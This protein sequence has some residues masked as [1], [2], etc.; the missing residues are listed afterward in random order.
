MI[1]PPSNSDR[2]KAQSAAFA[3]LHPALQRW[4]WT[5]GWPSLRDIQE[6]AI[7]AILDGDKDILISAAT[8]GGKTEA[9]ILP[10]LTRV[11]AADTP[12]IRVMG[13]SPLKALINDQYRRLEEIGEAVGLPIHRWHGDV[14]EANKSRLLKHPA[15]L[16][17]ITPESLEAMFVRRGTLIRNLFAGLGFIVVDELHAFVGSERGRQLQTLLHRLEL[18]LRRRVPRIGLSAT[19]GDMGMAAEFLRPAGGT[20]VCQIASS[21]Q[22]GEVRLQLR[23]YI[24]PKMRRDVTEEQMG[25]SAFREIVEHIYENLRRRHNL[26]FVNQKSA[27]EKYSD[28]LRTLCETRNVPNEFFPHHGSLSKGLRE[29][30]E[31]MLKSGDTPVSAVCTSTLELGIDIGDVE[32][33]AQI[34][35]PPAVASMRQRLGRSGRRGEPAVL[36]I[37]IDEPEISPATPVLDTMRL[38]TFETAAMVSLLVAGWCEPPIPHALHLSTLL[39]QSL[40]AIAQVGGAKAQ[41]LWQGLCQSGPFLG[42]DNAMFAAFLRSLAA[43]GLLVQSSEGVLLLGE[44]GERLVNNYDFYSA[45]VTDD[46]YRIEHEGRPLGSIPINHALIPGQMLIFGGR[47]WT[48]QHVDD[49]QKRISVIPA[50]G[51]TPPRYFGGGAKIHDRV[52]ENMFQLYVGHDVP[53]FLDSGAKKL[54]AQGRESFHEL[55]LMERRIVQHGDDCHTFLWTG[56]RV[57]DTIVALL[58]QRNVSSAPC[59]IC[60]LTSGVDER[61]II[62][63]FEA[64]LSEPPQDPKVLASAVRNKRREKHDRFLTEELLCADYASRDLDVEGARRVL[65][66]VL[67]GLSPIAG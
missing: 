60:L 55:R 58:R 6:R 30:V 5:Q 15:G 32:T 53:A 40:S 31:R 54:F 24:D 57:L 25:P 17:L 29:D 59:A 19:I 42:I 62:G 8:A 43:N 27:V 47:R 49:E 52:R 51:G 28:G 7:P 38:E 10:I 64:I 34:G 16:L 9:A 35:S 21:D 22:G 50:R 20:H 12:G 36:R 2:G 65:G 44:A 14:A 39:Q 45:F 66:R 63:H 61:G 48:V 56:D 67:D 18:V 4:I 13:V 37:Y 11:V 23:G 1:S 46:E 41:D 3:R 33:I 26:I